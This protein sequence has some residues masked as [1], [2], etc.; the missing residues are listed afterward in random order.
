MEGTR[1]NKYIAQS[2]SYSRRKADQLILNGNVKVNG[3][4]MKSPGYIVVPSD[5]V[6]VNGIPQIPYT[7]K[8][9]YA[10]NKPLGC[11]T[12]MEDDGGRFTVGDIIREAGL[13]VFPVGRLDYNTSGLLFLTNDGDFAYAVTHPKHKLEKVYLVRVSG[14][15]SDSKL[16]KLRKGV[17]IGGFTTSP[18]KV[19]VVKQ[20]KG[21]TVLEM[22]IHEGKNRQVR[23][24]IGAV[25][26]QVR[27]LKR[28]AIGNVKLGR[29]KEGSV[30]KL[31]QE[32]VK[33]L[34]G[35]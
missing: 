18:A 21:S 14:F 6:E 20:E 23:K 35:N 30:R 29:L 32:E 11:I 31:R 9:Y 8:S 5:M 22:T 34:I 12:T 28:I 25:G 27:E 17:D 10:F 15:L 19:N 3:A 13:K 4:T 7:K 16:T 26:H 1:I 2:G 24:M 33:G